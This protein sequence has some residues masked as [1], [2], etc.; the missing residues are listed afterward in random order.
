MM[1]SPNCRDAQILFL[2]YFGQRLEWDESINMQKGSRILG[3]NTS[4]EL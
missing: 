2:T 1:Q 3:N 4:K